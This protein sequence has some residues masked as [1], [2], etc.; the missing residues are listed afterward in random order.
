MQCRAEDSNTQE[1][2]LTM[3][4]LPHL[5]LHNI[6]NPGMAHLLCLCQ[7]LAIKPVLLWILDLNL[8]KYI[9][10]SAGG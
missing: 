3:G 10:E 8:D 9:H 4:P 6:N 2:L 1:R 7:A 5:L